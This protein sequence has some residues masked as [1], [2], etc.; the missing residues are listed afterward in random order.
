MPTV[1]IPFAGAQGKT[2]LD[3]PDDARRALSLAMLRD[4]LAACVAVART[5]VVT[6]DPDG[7]GAAREAGAEAVADPGGG[8]GEAVA[9]AL[10]ALPDEPVL[11]VNADLPCVAADDVRALL[12]AAPRDG[13][14][15]AAAADGT[16]NA[17]R[18]PAPAAFA[19]LYGRGSAD[20]F[21]AHAAALGLEAVSVSLPNLEDDVDTLDDLSRLRPRCGPHTRACLAELEVPFA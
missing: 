21:R 18:L 1:V 4:V 20:R 14:A 11:L 2:R 19:P 10:G 13:L 17:L 6:P 15:F 16:T 12:E 7:A 9:A 8:Q 3:V 5:L